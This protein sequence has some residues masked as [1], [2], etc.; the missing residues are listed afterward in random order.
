MPGGGLLRGATSLAGDDA[1]L[2]LWNLLSE[3][4]DMGPTTVSKLVAAKRPHLVP[5]YELRPTSPHRR[6]N[7]SNVLRKWPGG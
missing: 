3:Q 5:I 2:E 6:T 4:C 7:C 1:A